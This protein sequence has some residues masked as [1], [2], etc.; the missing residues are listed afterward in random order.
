MQMPCFILASNTY[1]STIIMPLLVLSAGRSLTIALAV[2]LLTVACSH[3]KVVAPTTGAITG[4]MAPNASAGKLL[5]VTA[6]ASNKQEYMATV[7]GLTGSF[8]FNGLPPD[9]YELKFSTTAAS[10]FPHWITTTVMAGA[11]ATPVIPPITHDNIARGTLKWIVNG[12]ACQVT[13]FSRIRCD[14]KTFDISGKSEPLGRGAFVY[15]IGLIATEYGKTPF[16]GVGTYTL[17]G[18]GTISPCG[19]VLF[20]PT[21]DYFMWSEYFTIPVGPP[22]GTLRLIR[23]DAVQGIATGTFE[24][25]GRWGSGN[26]NYPDPSAQVSVT[27]GEFDI[28]F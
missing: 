8:V 27:S 14:E 2:G 28:T 20:Y 25:V 4:T 18:Q 17:G 16:T 23:Y 26:A 11:T 22:T 5:S 1:F 21:G 24:F 10:S 7:D 9:T 19:T 13:E 3:D 12:K 6:T 15:Q